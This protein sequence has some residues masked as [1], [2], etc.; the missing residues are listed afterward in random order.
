[1]LKQRELGEVDKTV[2]GDL[3]AVEKIQMLEGGELREVGKAFVVYLRV[4]RELQFLDESQFWQQLQISVFD[5]DGIDNVAALLDNLRVTRDEGNGD[6]ESFPVETDTLDGTRS[7]SG[8]GESVT[9]FLAKIFIGREVD[10]HAPSDVV[11]VDDERL[12]FGWTF[13]VDVCE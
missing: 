10:M 11:W 6:G 5:F 2:V 13:I 3:V 8:F 1:M 9:D 4:P 7:I 12:K